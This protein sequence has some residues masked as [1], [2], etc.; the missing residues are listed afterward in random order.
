MSKFAGYH[1]QALRIVDYLYP[2]TAALTQTRNL[3]GT[4][5]DISTV[6]VSLTPSTLERAGSLSL[7]E[8]VIFPV[9]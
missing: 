1:S 3:R 2:S 9:Q 6:L 7:A 8:G 5:Y 4:N